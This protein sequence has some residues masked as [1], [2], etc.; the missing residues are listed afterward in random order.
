MNR[1]SE[2]ARF[3]DKGAGRFRYK[4]KGSGVVRDTLMAIGKRLAKAA[5]PLAKKTAPK[6][7]EK[8]AEKASQAL[9]ERGGKKIRQ[10]LR[11][12]IAKQKK[13]RQTAMD[14]MV[15]LSQILANQ[16]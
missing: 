8:A 2:W 6:A 12:R 3:Y 13:P 11:S 9:V 1:P 7:A 10:L 4:H 14:S 15:K 16:L 5:A